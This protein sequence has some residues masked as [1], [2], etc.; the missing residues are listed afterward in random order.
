VEFAVDGHDGSESAGSDTGDDFEAEDP[1]AGGLVG[2]DVEFSL[3]GVEE[4]CGAFDVAGGASAELYV[5]LAQGLEAELIVEGGDA[6]DFA[7]CE[8]EVLSDALDGVAAEVSDGV[9]DVLEDGNEGVALCVG[10]S[11][12]HGV[13]V[14]F[15][16]EIGGVHTRSFRAK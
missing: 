13:D 12:E 16:D 3:D 8:V 11:L 6:V 10:V 9:L 15:C 4:F 14:V 5:E 7:G 1:V 2:L